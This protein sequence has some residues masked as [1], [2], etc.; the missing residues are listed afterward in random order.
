MKKL[1]VSALTAMALSAM[2]VSAAFAGTWR[3]GASSPDSWW[4]DNGDG[5]YAANGWHWIDG[6]GDGVEECYCF[7]AN[8]WLYTGTVTPD[9]FTVD[10][11]GAWTDGGS[12]RTRGAAA[13]AAQAAAQGSA[14]GTAQGAS[15]GTDL[16]NAAVFAGTYEGRTEDGARVTAVVT[17]TADGGASV[18]VSIPDFSISFTDVYHYEA[19]TEQR[20]VVWGFETAGEKGSMVVIA[21]DRIDIGY[22]V[23]T[24]VN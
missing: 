24:R 21:P 11:N 20:G 5:S 15:Q 19:T 16:T 8:G 1:Y 14:A 17:P 23:M 7:D 18:A 4:Y 10:A 9:G 6:N 3:T 13:G 12:V 2:S 22:D